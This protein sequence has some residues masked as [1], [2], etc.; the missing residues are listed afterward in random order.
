MMII[1]MHYGYFNGPFSFGFGILDMVVMAL[2]LA[3]IVI[4]ITS[5]IR[6]MRFGGHHHMRH[7][8]RWGGD[9][10]LALLRERFAKGEIDKKEF[11]ERRVE[12]EKE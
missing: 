10:A 8:Q 6:W 5:L 11:E 1:M 12:L 7:M 4:A 9:P 2:W 3:L